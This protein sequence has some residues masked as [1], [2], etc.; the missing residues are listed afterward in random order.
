[1]LFRSKAISSRRPRRIDGSK[2]GLVPSVVIAEAMRDPALVA[3]RGKV[4][5]KIKRAKNR[6][7]RAR[8]GHKRVM[9]MAA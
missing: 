5:K 3:R 1:M 9:K 7:N 6:N 8:R 4:F 2:C